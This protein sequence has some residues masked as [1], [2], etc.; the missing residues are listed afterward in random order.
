MPFVRIS[1]AEELSAITKQNISKAIHCS[2]IQEFNIPEN[3][4]FHVIEELKP[5]QLFY[6]ESYLDINHTNRMLYIQIIAGAGRTLEQKKNL[7]FGKGEIQ[8]V[9]HLKQIPDKSE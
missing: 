8:E 3:D 9:K 2:L 7:S 1:L 4:Y 5:A 6:P